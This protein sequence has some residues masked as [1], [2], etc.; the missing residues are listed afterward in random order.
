MMIRSEL[1]EMIISKSD[2]LYNEALVRISE[3]KDSVSK[4]RNI[5]EDI[6]KNEISCDQE[7]KNDT[8]GSC[9]HADEGKKGAGKTADHVTEMALDTLKGWLSPESD[10]K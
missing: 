2:R 4:D 6:G 9:D 10:D 3:L 8:P 5:E 1:K 7:K